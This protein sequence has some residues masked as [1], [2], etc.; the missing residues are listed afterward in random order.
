MNINQNMIAHWRACQSA[1]IVDNQTGIII[2]WTKVCIAPEP[3]DTQVPYF[4]AIIA[5]DNSR[6]MLCP[7][8]DVD[9]TEIYIGAQ[10]HFVVRIIHSPSANSIVTYHIKAVVR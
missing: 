6:Q 7:V 3:F 9:E 1:P 2:S 10:V 8:V 4:L 5:V